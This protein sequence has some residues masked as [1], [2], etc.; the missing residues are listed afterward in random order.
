[1]RLFFFFAVMLA[2]S[3]SAAF[4][5]TSNQIEIVSRRNL[6]GLSS[7]GN[8]LLSPSLFQNSIQLSHQQRNS[9]TACSMAKEDEEQSLMRTI[10][11]GFVIILFVST[12]IFLPLMEGGG[13]RDLSIA[14]SV[15]TTQDNPNKLKDYEDNKS[16][17]SRA[18]IQEKLNSLPI[19]YLGDGEK[20]QQNLYFSYSDALA[21]TTGSFRVKATSLDQVMYPLILKRGR[22]VSH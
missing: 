20:M 15:V 7:I 13:S 1:M 19:F 18:A 14:D 5:P 16:R 4:R 10:S 21:A 22:M 12:S 2:S 9:R 11:I 3:S 6:C 8:G 17:L